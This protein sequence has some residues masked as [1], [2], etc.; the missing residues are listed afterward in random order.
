MLRTKNGTYCTNCY[1]A[2]G[3]S[4]VKLDSLEGCMSRKQNYLFFMTVLTI[5]LFSSSFF[6]VLETKGKRLLSCLKFNISVSFI[7]SKHLK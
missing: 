7:N 4:G 6:S 2:K 3:I 1:K 5:L